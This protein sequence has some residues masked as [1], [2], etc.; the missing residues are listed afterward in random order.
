MAPSVCMSVI[1]AGR[2]STGGSC[3][4]ECFSL[5]VRILL[6]IH[7]PQL[8]QD[9][10]S[11]HNPS[12]YCSLEYKFHENMHF[13]LSL[14]LL[15]PLSRT[16]PG[17]QQAFIKLNSMNKWK[18]SPLLG[19][20]HFQ[21]CF[22]TWGM[23]GAHVS[24]VGPPGRAGPCT[25]VH[26]AEWRQLVWVQEQRQGGKELTS[27]GELT[28]IRGSGFPSLRIGDTSVPVYGGRRAQLTSGYT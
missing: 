10:I 7:C 16:V 13:C 23:L 20:T 19:A 2:K 25:W 5:E 14:S 21:E 24:F 27:C 11:Q 18:S 6:T 17:P 3:T 22:Q 1:E 9:P 15:Y 8:S 12:I 28:E 26:R 4:N